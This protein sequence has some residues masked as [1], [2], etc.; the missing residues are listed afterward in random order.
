MIFRQVTSSCGKRLGG[1]ERDVQ[2]RAGDGRIRRSKFAEKT[3]D[4][5]GGELRQRDK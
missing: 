5:I 2:N 3:L 4:L 1:V